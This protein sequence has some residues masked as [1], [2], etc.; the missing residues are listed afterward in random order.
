MTNTT[1]KA[2]SRAAVVAA[3]P[4]APRG[5]DND[6]I[7][8]IVIVVMNTAVSCHRSCYIVALSWLC[9]VFYRP[10]S[11]L[12]SRHA[13]PASSYH[14]LAFRVCWRRSVFSSNVRHPLHHLPFARMIAPPTSLPSNSLLRR[15]GHAH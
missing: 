8:V 2:I 5:A 3:V 7:I 15:P 12:V 14:L 1:G 11:I 4:I 6:V 9:P 10:L 13:V